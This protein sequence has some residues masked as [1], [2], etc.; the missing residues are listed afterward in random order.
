MSILLTYR[1]LIYS[2]L[3]I[4]DKLIF[5]EAVQSKFVNTTVKEVEGAASIWL[6]KASDRLK[7]KSC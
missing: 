7:N 2:I 1:G 5:L 3:A 4:T 6:T